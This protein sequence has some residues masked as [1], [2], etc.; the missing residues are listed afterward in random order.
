MTII[1]QTTLELLQGD[2]TTFTTDGIVNP[3]ISTGAHRPQ[4]THSLHPSHTT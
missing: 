2:I 1:N 4:L 3:A